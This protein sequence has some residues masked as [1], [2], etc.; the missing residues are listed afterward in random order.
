MNCTQASRGSGQVAGRHDG[1]RTRK[2]VVK[3]AISRDEAGQHGDDRELPLSRI[4]IAQ[5]HRLELDGVLAAL[6]EDDRGRKGR[7]LA[8]ELHLLHLAGRARDEEARR[9]QDWVQEAVQQGARIVA[10]VRELRFGAAVETAFE[11]VRTEVDASIEHGRDGC[12]LYLILKNSWQRPVL[13]CEGR[14]AG[15]AERSQRR[16]DACPQG[17]GQ[18][19]EG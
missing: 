8:R 3:V 6:L 18:A 1:T 4:E 7:S 5:E 9:A 13:A 16:R 17:R 12:Y 14:E 2:S 15:T 11:V 19:R 10:Q